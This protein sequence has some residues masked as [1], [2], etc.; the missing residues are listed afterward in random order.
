MGADSSHRSELAGCVL[1]IMF[2]VTLGVPL[3]VIGL[4]IAV[5]RRA[6]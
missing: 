1:G 6:G 5:V 4:L 3:S 2:S